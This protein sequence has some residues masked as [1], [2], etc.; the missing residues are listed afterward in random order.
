PR[1][2]VLSVGV[3][4][5]LIA[6]GLLIARSEQARADYIFTT[7]APPGSTYARAWGI[8]NSGQIAG[9]YSDA[10]NVNH[11]FVYSNGTYTTLDA[12]GASGTLATG[13]NDA[14]QVVGYYIVRLQGEALGTSGASSFDIELEFYGFLFSDGNYTTLDVPGVGSPGAHAINNFGQIVGSTGPRQT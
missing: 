11:G 9:E 3:L 12:P 1:N 4:N 5:G 14:G 6:L 8:N 7:I 13:I 10:S 2:R